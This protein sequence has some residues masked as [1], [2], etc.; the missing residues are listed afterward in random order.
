M[1]DPHTPA[2]VLVVDDDSKI[3]ALLERVLRR[4]GHFIV[5]AENGHAA[6]AAV[7]REPP[8]VI[9]TDVT[10]PGMDGFEL[11]QRLKMNVATRSIRRSYASAC[12]R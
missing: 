8:D 3:R 1:P 4:D 2:R 10:M 5:T 9:L 6:L 7:E 12:V 11:C